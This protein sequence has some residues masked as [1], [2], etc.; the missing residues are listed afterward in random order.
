MRTVANKNNTKTRVEKIDH[1]KGNFT[2]FTIDDLYLKIKSAIP[3]IKL[4]IGMNESVPKLTRAIGNDDELKELAANNSLNIGA[5]HAIVILL[6][7]AFPIHVLNIIKSHPCICRI[8]GASSNPLQVVVSETS[9]GSAVLGI[10][11]GYS[12]NKIETPS[13]ESERRELVK[14]LGY[15]VF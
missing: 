12:A 14:K 5:G 1:V 4:G 3:G 9:L 10:V 13:Q 11:D 7:N 6:K 2:V 8:Y 15:S